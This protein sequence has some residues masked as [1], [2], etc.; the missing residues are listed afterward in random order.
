MK[1]LYE[2]CELYELYELY[3]LGNGYQHGLFP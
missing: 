2:P 3:E 1:Y